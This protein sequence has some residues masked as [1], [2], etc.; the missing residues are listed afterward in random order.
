M[1]THLHYSNWKIEYENIFRGLKKNKILMFFSGGKDSSFLLDY[2]IRAGREFGFSFETHAGAFPIHRYTESERESMG[3]YWKGRGVEI[4]WHEFSEDDEQI[5]SSDNPCLSCQKI[6]KKVLHKLVAGEEDLTKLVMVVSYSLWDLV[7]Y[8]IEHI[9]GDIFVNSGETADRQMSKRFIET[10]QRFYPILTM[11][12]GYTLFRPLV[13]YD[14]KT[15]RN[16]IKKLGI[17]ILSTPC[18]F[19]DYRPKRVLEKYYD[20][21]VVDFDYDKVFQFAKECLNLPETSFYSS[22]EKDRYLKD[23]F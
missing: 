9:L 18:E 10:S 13:R 15:I 8:A 11:R 4:I 14:S 12:E 6:R 21:M 19:K 20:K 1:V 22:I 2:L 16:K 17:P 23:V 7:S 5:R 3:S